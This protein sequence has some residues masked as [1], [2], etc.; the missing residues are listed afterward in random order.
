MLF[1]VTELNFDPKGFFVVVGFIFSEVSFIKLASLQIWHK[2]KFC[3][4][5]VSVIINGSF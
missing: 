5:G 3:N 4:C 2:N 1:I